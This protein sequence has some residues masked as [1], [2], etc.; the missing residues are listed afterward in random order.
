M[1]SSVNNHDT[2]TSILSIKE[3]VGI[4]VIFSLV[5][6]L[7]FPKENIDEILEGEGGN[8]NLSIN[9]LESMLL[10]YPNSVKLKRILIRNYDDAGKKR[11]A[12]ALTTKLIIEVEDTEILAELYK[13]EYLLNKDIYFQ[14]GDKTLLPK[15]EKK[16]YDYF[17]YAYDEKGGIDYMFF[18]AE[19]TQMDFPNLKY[20][21]LDGLMKQSPKLADYALEKEMFTLALSLNDRAKAYKY[22]LRLLEYNEME[23]ELKVYAVGFL[24]E[25]KEY[26]RAKELSTWL[27]LHSKNRE[28]IVNYFNIALYTTKGDINSTREIISLYKNSREL[29]ASDIQ[30]ILNSLLQIGDIEGASIFATALFRTNLDSFDENVTEIAVKSLIY[31]QKL[32]S[33]LEISN[34]AYSEFNNIK[35][36]DKSIQLSTWLGDIKSTI[37]LNIEGYR[38][39]SDKKYEKYLLEYTTLDTAYEILGEIYKN[40]LKNGDYSMVEKVAEYYDYIGAVSEAEKFFLELFK[41]DKKESIHKQ[42]ISFA[43]KNSH[44]KKALNLYDSYKKRYGVDENLQKESITKLISLKK[45]KKA[46]KFTQELEGIE[47]RH[48]KKLQALLNKLKIHDEF[49]LRRKLMDL[50]WIERDYR[51][52]YDI[53]WKWESR[54]ELK[55]AD[56]EKLIYL[57]KSF[58]DRGRLAYLYK[59]SWQKTK[60]STFLYSLLSLYIDN[61]EPKKFKKLINSL[62]YKYRSSLAKETRYNILMANYYIQIAQ[63]KKAKKSFIKALKIDRTNGST[64]QAYLWFLIDNKLNKSLKKELALLR[65]NP[66]LQREVGFASVVASLMLQQ[67]DLALRWLKPLLKSSDNIEYQV[68]YADILQLQDREAGA[69]KVRLKLFKRLNEMVKKSPNLL[70][71]K[72][73]A[74]VYLRMVVFYTTPYEKKAI[75]FDKFKSLFSEKEFGEIRIGWSAYKQSDTKAKY[76]STKYKLDIPWLNLYLSINR[77]NKK[78][79]QRLLRN[80]KSILAFR[81]RVIASIDIGERA[82]AYSLAFMGLEDNSRDTDLYKIFDDMVNRDYPKGELSS[83]YKRLSP[84]ISMIENGISYRWQLYKGVESK[85]SYTRYKYQRKKDRDLKDDTLA[86]SLKNSDKKF[87]W[88]FTIASH[89]ADNSFISSKLNLKYKLSDITLGI[90]SKY[91]NKTKQTPKLQTQAMED[92]ISLKLNRPLSKRVQLSLIH[93]ESRYKNQDKNILGSSSHTQLSTNYLL[94]AGYPDIRFNWYLTNN[95]YENRANYN[96]L[97]S[98][99]SEFGTQ[100]SIGSSAKDRIQ[101]SWRPFGALGL[102]I[103]NKK[104]IGTSLSLGL[105]GSLRGEDSFSL[106]VD[107]SK[108]IDMVS[109]PSYGVHLKYNF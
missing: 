56:Y 45:F 36:L 108:G 67:T 13:R 107:Y 89:R 14:T 17:G 88:D 40:R 84:K 61:R 8:T 69:S 82:E 27:F 81:D 66:K 16:L 75:Y 98:D 22:L 63:I 71:D 80:N 68:V 47:K 37:K 9:Y 25:Y 28:D 44:F 7:V 21:A 105:S 30:I 5:L 6:Y 94:R 96:L 53:L 18:L 87:L 11:K 97:P 90:E 3:I 70:K 34:Y 78:L 12:L 4:I 99:F 106:A 23:R 42:A 79:K 54:D 55:T 83:K 15:I 57:E 103:N 2:S 1:Y 49:K 86:L 38:E 48:D 60:R 74:R 58:K 50:A 100:L 51:Y 26:K 91:Q 19:A 65:K 95:E 24:L 20:I 85:F 10:Y 64:H 31:N 41:R 104:D 73:F 32:A 46:Y 72:S 52:I 35:W 102:V 59:K 43:F 77:D 92:S 33:A 39:G 101:R 93:R 76:L 62:N 109:S 29:K